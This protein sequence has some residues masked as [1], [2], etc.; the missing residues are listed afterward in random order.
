MAKRCR[1]RVKPDPQKDRL[2]K[3]QWEWHEW[4]RASATLK[5]LQEAVD[6]ACKLW[7]VRTVPVSRQ[8]KKL[9]YS[10]YNDGDRTIRL[11]PE[12]HNLAMALH[13]VAHHIVDV[14]YGTAYPH[15]GKVFVGVFA[16][17]LIDFKLA[18]KEAVY[19]SLKARKIKYTLPKTTVKR[20]GR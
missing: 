15:H 2:Y 4:N 7:G 12:H 20:K 9:E 8:P 14:R 10:V 13:E 16:D 5:E 19:A 18:P 17:L 3:W 11:L 1:R 6:K